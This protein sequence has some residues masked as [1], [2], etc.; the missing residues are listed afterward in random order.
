[1]GNLYGIDVEVGNQFSTNDFQIIL[2][3]YYSDN[4]TD[5]FSVNDLMR[6]VR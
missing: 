3:N 4:G 5:L 6:R 1:M 2:E